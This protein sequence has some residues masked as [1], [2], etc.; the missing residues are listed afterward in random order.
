MPDSDQQLQNER[1]EEAVA[2]FGAA[3]RRLV[4]GYEADASAQGDLLQ[5]I[6]ID[7]WRS[8]A[9]LRRAL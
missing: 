2:A 3:L 5:E 4:N 7:L 6:H 9:R 1:Y 8:L